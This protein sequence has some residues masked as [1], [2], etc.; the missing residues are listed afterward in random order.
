MAITK[1]K[2][3]D[4]YKEL[5]KINKKLLATRNRLEDEVEALMIVRDDLQERL[6]QSGV[7][8][9]NNER[10]GAALANELG[11][12]KRHLADAKEVVYRILKECHG[13]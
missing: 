7:I 2:L 6:R 3:E 10:A 4:R 1:R 8:C 9:N 5:S 12:C 13:V 11:D